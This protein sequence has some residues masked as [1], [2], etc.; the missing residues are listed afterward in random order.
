MINKSPSINYKGVFVNPKYTKD[1]KDTVKYELTV[2]MR[3][4]DIE[5]SPNC[6]EN[7]ADL[8]KRLRENSVYKAVDLGGIHDAKELRKFLKIYKKIKPMLK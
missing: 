2:T 1:F 5:P 6:Y 4:K 7:R 3:L 8:I